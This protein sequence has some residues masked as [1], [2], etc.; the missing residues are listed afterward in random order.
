MQTGEVPVANAA[1]IK[2]KGDAKTARM[3]RSSCFP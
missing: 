2:H 3:A 1:G